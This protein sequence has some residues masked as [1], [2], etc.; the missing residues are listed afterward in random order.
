MSAKILLGT[1]GWNYPDWVGSFYPPGTRAPNMLRLYARAFASVEVDSTFYTIPAEPVVDSWRERVPD[2]FIFALKVPQEIT[3]EKRLVGVE[4]LLNRFCARVGRLGP[5]LGPL[6]VQLS[7]EFRPSDEHQAA[8]T[9]FLDLRPAGYRWAIEFRH[10]GWLAGATLDLLRKHNVA[11][12]LADSRWIKRGLMLELAIEPTADFG[13]I[14]WMGEERRFSD[15]SQMQLDRESDH[16]RWVQAV[17]Q[18]AERV[19][20]IFGYFNNQY[21]G[22]SPHSARTMQRLSGLPAVAPELLQEQVELF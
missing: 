16:V 7:P 3:H 19:G 18:L 8:L 21:E 17:E 1:Q 22:H 2:Q 20:M 4:Q 14:R 9:A 10:P 5:T 11:V 13:Y 15:F 6:L 12:A